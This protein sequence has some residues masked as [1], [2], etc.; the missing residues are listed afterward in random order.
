[1]HPQ[2][3]ISDSPERLCAKLKRPPLAMADAHGSHIQQAYLEVSAFFWRTALPFLV[4]KSHV[5]V[6][7]TFGVKHSGEVLP[8]LGFPASE[9]GAHGLRS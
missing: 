6:D 1:M 4:Q 3:Q 9:Y 7:T 8:G 2:L 5:S